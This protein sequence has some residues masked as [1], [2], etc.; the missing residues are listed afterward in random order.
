MFIKQDHNEISASLICVDHT[1]DAFTSSAMFLME[2]W[3]P[4]DQMDFN[5]KNGHKHDYL[6]GS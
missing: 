2:Q 4:N 5:F 6:I 1:K 3:I